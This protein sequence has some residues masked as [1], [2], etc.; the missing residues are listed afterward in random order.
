MS[1]SYVKLTGRLPF[2][3]I[4]MNATGSK[5]ATTL[6]LIIPALLFMNSSRGVCACAAR[7][8]MSMGRDQILPHS[9]IFQIVK[10]GEPVIGLALSSAVALLLGLVQL[11]STAA[12]NSLLGTSTIMFQITY[13]GY[14]LSPRLTLTPVM[15]PLLMLFG[16]RRRLNQYQAKR[17]FNLGKWGV[18]LNVVSCFFVLE[19]MVIYC[20]PAT[21]ASLSS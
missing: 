14:S 10:M 6:F 16:G 13:G 11:G 12:F 7:V 18:V 5:A 19:G 3:Q 2:A 4:V 8:L 21:M 17:S 20:F 1:V 15:P 9:H